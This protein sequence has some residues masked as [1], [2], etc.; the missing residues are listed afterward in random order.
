MTDA[1]H[2]EQVRARLAAAKK[3]HPYAE[4]ERARRELSTNAAADLARLLRRAE[5]AEAQV[6]RYVEFSGNVSWLRAKLRQAERV[7]TPTATPLEE[8][9]TL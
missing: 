2:G 9:Q 3:L 5:R 1:E 8:G 6:A 7:A 4:N